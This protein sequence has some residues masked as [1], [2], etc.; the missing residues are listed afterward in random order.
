VVQTVG[1]EIGR[2]ECGSYT[3]ISEGILVTR[4]KERDRK[5]EQKQGRK[6]EW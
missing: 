5:R 3:G 1:S 2:K 4:M 6:K